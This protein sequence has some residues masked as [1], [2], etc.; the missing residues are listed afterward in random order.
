MKYHSPNTE[1]TNIE[2]YKTV[3][4]IFYVPKTEPTLMNES[5]T[6]DTKYPIVSAQEQKKFAKFVVFML[7]VVLPSASFVVY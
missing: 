4:L 7:Y 2:V 6:A 3:I 5:I 1:K